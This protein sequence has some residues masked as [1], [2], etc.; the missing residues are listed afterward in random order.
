[1]LDLPESWR[2]EVTKILNRYA[3]EYHVL[4]YGSRVNGTSHAGSDLDLV[5]RHPEQPE[6]GCSSLSDIT[7]ALRESSI[8][9]SVD[10]HD[11]A[12]LPQELREEINRQFV[13]VK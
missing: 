7:A 4:A 11:W 9:I 10:L 3:P 6:L 1:M 2:Q 8:P 5:I 12:Q 13:L